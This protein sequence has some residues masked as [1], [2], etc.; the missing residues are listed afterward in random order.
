MRYFLLSHNDAAFKW[1]ALVSDE[2]VQEALK[3]IH[4]EDLLARVDRLKYLNILQDGDITIQMPL[5]AMANGLGLHNTCKATVEMEN[6]AKD[7]N[8]NI[9]NLESHIDDQIA[10]LTTANLNGNLNSILDKIKKTRLKLGEKKDQIKDIVFE[11]DN[12][13][14]IDVFQEWLQEILSHEHNNLKAIIVRPE[15]QDAYALSG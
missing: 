14:N 10:L 1:L 7:I 11:I 13:T 8:S 12:D 15:K 6:F 3:T 5:M 4:I 2:V 9:E